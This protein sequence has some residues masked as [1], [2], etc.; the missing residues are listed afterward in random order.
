MP[1]FNSTQP[2]H[3]GM[4]LLR[5][6]SLE[7]EALVE[8]CCPRCH[9]TDLDFKSDHQAVWCNECAEYILRDDRTVCPNNH[10]L[11]R[12][13]LASHLADALESYGD[14]KRE[15]KPRELRALVDHAAYLHLQVAE[16]NETLA[17]ERAR[18]RFTLELLSQERVQLARKPA[19]RAVFSLEVAS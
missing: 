8:D 12:V 6:A 17:A 4:S 18:L 15:V 19:A 5:R 7:D 2:E 13:T 3:A 11:P 1:E 10:T 16:L 9:S 14:P